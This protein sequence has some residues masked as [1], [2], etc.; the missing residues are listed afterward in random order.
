MKKKDS[1]VGAAYSDLINTRKTMMIVIAAQSIS[2]CV[3]VFLL[4]TTNQKTIVVP[5][6]ITNEITITEGEANRSYQTAFAWPIAELVGNVGP[7]NIDFVVKSLE[8]M[9]SPALKSTLIPAIKQ[10]TKLL[11][12]R[13]ISQ[14]F[15]VRDMIWSGKRDLVYVWGDKVTRAENSNK[16]ERELYTYEIRVKPVNGRPRVVHFK[17]YKGSPTKDPEQ[18]TQPST[19]FYDGDVGTVTVEEMKEGE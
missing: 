14:D 8:N 1:M 12:L 5:S 13:E 16:P 9:L 18:Q 2:L 10:E 7:R 19:P 6:E 11:K 4:L 17:G 3:L 15:I